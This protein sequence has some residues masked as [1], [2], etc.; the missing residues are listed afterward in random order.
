MTILRDILAALL[1]IKALL[2]AKFDLGFTE[3]E[4]ARILHVS[5]RFMR[6]LRQRALIGYS[7]LPGSGDEKPAI[8]YRLD[9]LTEYLGRQRFRP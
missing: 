2:I 7:V 5:P 3:E 9:D 8:R 6:S 1:D 4:A